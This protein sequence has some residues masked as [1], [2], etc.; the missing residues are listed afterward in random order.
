MMDSDPKKSHAGVSFSIRT[1]P[2]VPT[3]VSSKPE[4]T[5]PS[6][7]FLDTDVGPSSQQLAISIKVFWEIFCEFHR[8][9]ETMK[10]LEIHSFFRATIIKF[11][12]KS[13]VASKELMGLI[14]TFTLRN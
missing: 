9:I 14:A 8:K 4:G 5:F 11:L 13:L 7:C 2:P 12:E 1:S 3:S 10:F 6:F